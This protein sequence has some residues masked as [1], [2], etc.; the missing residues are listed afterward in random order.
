MINI[1]GELYYIDLIELDRVI[2]L[3]SDNNNDNNDDGDDI[4][5]LTKT[6][7]TSDGAGKV[8]N[9]KTIDNETV[10]IKEINGVRFD[11]IRSF[12][13]DIGETDDVDVDYTL[14]TRNLD[15]MG[16]K[17]KVAFNTLLFYKILKKLN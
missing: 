6:I 13:T 8:V 4:V 11:I 2:A 1:F 14:G 3:G 12:I 16:T 15:K 7:T 5:M 10:K 17:F 9:V